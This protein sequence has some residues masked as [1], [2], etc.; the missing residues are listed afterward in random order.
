MIDRGVFLRT[1]TL[2]VAIDV[3]RSIL[4][5]EIV[6]ESDYPTYEENVDAIRVIGEFIEDKGFQPLYYYSGNKSVHAH[7]FISWDWLKDLDILLQEQLKTK[8]RDSVSRFKIAFMKWLRE[9]MISCWDTGLKKF[10]SDL[11]NGTHL[12]RCELS[13]NKKGYKTFLGYTYKDVSPIPYICNEKNR[14]YPQLGEIKSSVPNNPQELIEE[15]IINISKK[16]KKR[17]NNSLYKWGMGEK[18]QLRPCVKILL[19]NEFIKIGDGYR[20]A[21]FI[22][23]NELKKVLGLEQAEIIINNWNERCSNP[24]QK[25]DIKERLKAKNYTLSND[26]IH[27]FLSEFDLKI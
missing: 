5:N 27:R 13:K 25:T 15:F 9:K 20:R 17:K 21:S 22:L 8:F 4:P 6:I 7:I 14:I 26:Y 1:Y 16:N 11:I 23:I 18:E 19:S 3:H 2:A 12:I 24:L 10:D